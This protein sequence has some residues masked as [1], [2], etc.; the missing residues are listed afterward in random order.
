MSLLFLILPCLAWAQYDAS[1]VDP[2]R[3]G[4]TVQ[5]ISFDRIHDGTILE[6][7]AQDESGKVY[8]FSIPDQHHHLAE[9]DILSPVSWCVVVTTK[10]NVVGVVRIGECTN[11]EKGTP[12]SSFFIG[13]DEIKRSLTQRR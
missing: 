1:R 3:I 8:A 9:K 10:F 2:V 13:T 11:E 6:I 12:N 7:R 5:F 4:K